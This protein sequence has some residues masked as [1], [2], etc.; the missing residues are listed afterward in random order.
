MKRLKRGPDKSYLGWGLLGTYGDGV[1]VLF[2]APD[3]KV[4]KQIHDKYGAAV[5]P[6]DPK[7]SRRVKVVK[8]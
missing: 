7:K 2:V 6:Y 4:L 1:E 5:D 8:G 3:K